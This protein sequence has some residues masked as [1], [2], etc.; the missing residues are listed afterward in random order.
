[1][2]DW[3]TVLLGTWAD[4]RHRERPELPLFGRGGAAR[5]TIFYLGSDKDCALCC[6]QCNLRSSNNTDHSKISVLDVPLHDILFASPP[7]SGKRE[8]PIIW[9][10]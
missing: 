8:R 4:L 10:P 1:M 9:H 5:G 6:D 7:V 3:M 2:L